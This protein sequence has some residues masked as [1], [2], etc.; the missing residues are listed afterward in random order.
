MITSY[1]LATLNAV[2]NSSALCCVTLGY[3]AVRAGDIPRHRRYMLGAFVLSLIFLVSYATRMLIFGDQHFAGHGPVRLVYFA[4]LI[5]HVLLAA[6]V[7]PVVL[8][9]VV[10]GLRDQRERH[11]KIAPRV[12]P[13]WAYVLVTGVV[14]YLLL[15]HYPA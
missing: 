12:L 1:A 8:Y 2:L 9:T 4:I 11:R 6:A 3:R 13:V 15:F 5:S 14:V 10:L 7:A